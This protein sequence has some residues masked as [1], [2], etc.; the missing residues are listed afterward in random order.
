MAEKNDGSGRWIAET[1][2]DRVGTGRSDLVAGW[3]GLLADLLEKTG[4]YLS[5]G[6]LVTF[7]ALRSEERTFFEALVPAV[8]VPVNVTALYISPS[9]RQQMLGGPPPGEGSG[10]V[11]GKAAK[12]P[13]TGIV[14]A[15]RQD[16]HTTIVN[17]LFAHPPH[18][19][20]ID[21]YE[22]GELIAG[23][24]YAGLE[25]L[26]D[27]LGTILQRHLGLKGQT[28]TKAR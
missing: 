7:R 6:R 17:A 2:H 24:S 13:D 14:L 19:P 5:A 1:I 10:D 22:N 20:A 4:P 28:T 21:V 11:F 25:A 23:Y 9:V 26:R 12:S 27:E 16:D 3:Q 8:P 15:C 18:T